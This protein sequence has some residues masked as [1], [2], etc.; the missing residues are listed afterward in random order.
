[1]GRLLF[2]YFIADMLEAAGNVNFAALGKMAYIVDGGAEGMVGRQH[3]Q[4]LA[5]NVEIVHTQGH[6]QADIRLGEHDTLA[7]S[8]SARCIDDGG[9]PARVYLVIIIGMVSGSIPG[10]AIFP[11]GLEGEDTA[12]AA[13]IRL[14]R[15]L[16][17]N[18]HNHPHFQA[19]AA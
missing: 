18:G 13:L 3:M 8:G 5:G 16:R 9:E 15:A 14:E 4:G 10:S 19:P 1:M 7:P 6:V 12:A 17:I 11:E 2:A